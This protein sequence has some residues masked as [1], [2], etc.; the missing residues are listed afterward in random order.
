MQQ[1]IKFLEK[2]VSETGE[3][4]ELRVE[5]FGF[6]FDTNTE[7]Y[8]RASIQLDGITATAAHDWDQYMTAVAPDCNEA[9]ALLEALCAEDNAKWGE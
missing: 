5:H 7:P 8:F 6:D 1:I 2:V 9:L 4:A 3:S